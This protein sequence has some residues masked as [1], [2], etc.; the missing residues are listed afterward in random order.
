MKRLL[1]SLVF[2][3]LCLSSASA[4]ADS[5]AIKPY[6]WTGL[7]LGLQGSYDVGSTDWDSPIFGT[8]TDHTLKGEQAAFFSAIIINSP[9]MWLSALRQISTT[10][11]SR[12][13]QVALTVLILAIARL[14]G[15]VQHV[16]AWVM[17]FGDFFLMLRSV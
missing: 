17:L 12:V 13:H 16:P 3:V 14:I 4:F 11:K 10:A 8:H 1:F 9:S 7:Y 5:T 2:M 6:N 15:S